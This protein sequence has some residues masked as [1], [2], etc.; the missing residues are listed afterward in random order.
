MVTF[1]ATLL[2]Y[3]A[4]RQNNENE[5]NIDIKALEIGDLKVTEAL[6]SD[7]TFGGIFLHYL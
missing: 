2:I 6:L 4:R 3:V 1:F 7:E 5:A